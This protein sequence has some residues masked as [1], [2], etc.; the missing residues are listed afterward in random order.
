MAYHIAC[1][2]T[3]GMAHGDH[4][5]HKNYEFI[6]AKGPAPTTAF[7]RGLDLHPRDLDPVVPRGHTLGTA[8]G[9]CILEFTYV[10]GQ[11]PPSSA[12][13]AKSSTLEAESPWFMTNSHREWP[14][15]ATS[16]WETTRLP[17]P[18][19][20]CPSLALTPS[21]STVWEIWVRR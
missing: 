8:L 2:L 15:S 5:R 18:M 19:G 1:G 3:R 17:T 13:M 9:G 6:S 14:Q 21:R 7:S 20:Q 16:F 4:I 10:G 11:Y 12:V